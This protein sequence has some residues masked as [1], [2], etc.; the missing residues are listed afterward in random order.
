MQR[1]GK[2]L[3]EMSTNRQ[4]AMIIN[5]PNYINYLRNRQLAQEQQQQQKQARQQNTKK[6]IKTCSNVLCMKTQKENEKWMRC[7]GKNC[8]KYFCDQCGNYKVQH[9]I[10]CEKVVVA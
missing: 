8:R 1:H 10:R 2:S 7:K 6:N 3:N 9:E 4:R 5:N